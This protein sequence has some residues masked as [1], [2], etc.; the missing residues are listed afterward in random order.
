MILDRL[1]GAFQIA[2]SRKYNH[3]QSFVIRQNDSKFSFLMEKV[4]KYRNSRVDTF[5]N[6]KYKFVWKLHYVSLWKNWDK[7][8]HYCI[9]MSYVNVVNNWSNNDWCHQLSAC[10]MILTL[11]S[12]I[13]SH[14]KLYK[15]CQM[16]FFSIRGTFMKMMKKQ[17]ESL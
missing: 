2:K 8:S 1:T 12:M 16:I 10:V 13:R 5:N 3:M 15:S 11:I 9:K 14:R 6:T 7:I 4:T 17:Q